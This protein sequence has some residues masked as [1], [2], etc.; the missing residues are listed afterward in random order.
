MPHE[1]KICLPSC[2]SKTDVF[3]MYT[4]D[5]LASSSK[6]EAICWSSFTEM[7]KKHF[8]NVIIPKVNVL[9]WLASFND[10][11]ANANANANDNNARKILKKE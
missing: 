1:D 4:A 5:I 9:K 7:W 10:A 6:G 11:N 8:K 3:K 2:Q